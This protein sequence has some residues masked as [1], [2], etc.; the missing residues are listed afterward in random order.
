MV[1][2]SST[3]R[4]STNNL[5]EEEA[6]FTPILNQE[7]RKAFDLIIKGEN[8][9]ICGAAGTGKSH[10]LT[11]VYG[12]L[13]HLK[14]NVAVTAPTGVAA[15]NL[16]ESCKGIDMKATTI[17]SWIGAG[18]FDG[19]FQ[20]NLQKIKSARAEERWKSVDVLIIDEISMVSPKLFDDMDLIARTLRGNSKPF[21]GIQMVLCGD[22]FQLEPVRDNR[23]ID[24]KY[25]YVISFGSCFNFAY[26]D[27]DYCFETDLWNKTIKEEN[28]IELCEN[29]RQK[30]DPQFQKLLDEIREGIL[31]EESI[32]LL[33]SRI[34]ASLE[35]PA[36]IRP[37][38]LLPL[39]WQVKK[40]NDQALAEIQGEKVRYTWQRFDHNIEKK[41]ADKLFQTLVGRIPVDEK[42]YLKVGAPVMLL[43]N[44]SVGMILYSSLC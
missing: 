26:R 25:E 30:T 16:N 38:L 1:H 10:L 8:V 23:R 9:H 43:V 12:S 11:I 4:D 27:I 33:K 22:W 18:L 37:T 42:V 20:E 29:Y 2:T 19:S 35:N 32:I 6:T 13:R 39:V 5:M 41:E 24:E 34:N 36:G 3:E 31:T 7:Q 15:N 14:L 40:E 28:I 44:L 17:H 21:G